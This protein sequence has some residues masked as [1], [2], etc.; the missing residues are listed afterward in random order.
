MKILVIT[1]MI[2]QIL[3]IGSGI[4]NIINN[5][6]IFGLLMVLFNGFF[7]GVNFITLKRLTNNN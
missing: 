1:L 2:I 3:L 7:L 5:R 6:P 4:M